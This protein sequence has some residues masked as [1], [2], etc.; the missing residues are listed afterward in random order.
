ME[1]INIFEKKITFHIKYNKN[2]TIK[3]YANC[4]LLI[5][6][7]I[8][9]INRYCGIS[10]RFICDYATEILSFQNGSVIMDVLVKVANNKGKLINLSKD[11]AKGVF[12]SLIVALLLNN[13]DNKNINKYEE[14]YIE[15]IQYN[16]VIGK[17]YI[18]DN[19]LYSIKVVDEKTLEIK[20]KN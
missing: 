7:S 6:K 16:I 3:E 4:L 19:N 20:I 17:E 12:I 10:N 18:S 14:I 9:D 5:N 2:L 11:I 13:I 15:K 8:N 1:T